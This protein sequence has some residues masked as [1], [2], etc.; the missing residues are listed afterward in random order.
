MA[1]CSQIQQQGKEHTEYSGAVEGSEGSNGTQVSLSM[2]SLV[3]NVQRTREM[4]RGTP[5]SLVAAD[6]SRGFCREGGC[7]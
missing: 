3:S 5:E 7:G 1:A 6:V 2:E 4:L